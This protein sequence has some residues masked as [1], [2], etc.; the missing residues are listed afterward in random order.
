MDDFRDERAVVVT[1]CTLLC[2][3]RSALQQVVGPIADLRMA[4]R[5]Q[6]LRAVPM[7]A[8]M[9]QGLLQQIAEEL[10]PQTFQPNAVIIRQ[11]EE[12]RKFYIVESGV[13]CITDAHGNKVGQRKQGEFFGEV[14]LIRKEVRQANV[15]ASG[16][17]CRVLAMDRDVRDYSTPPLPGPAVRPRQPALSAPSSRLSDNDNWWQPAFGTACRLDSGGV[18]L[19]TSELLPPPGHLRVCHLQ[20]FE[21]MQS[22]SHR[23]HAQLRN[24]VRGYQPIAFKLAIN[25]LSDVK[26]RGKSWR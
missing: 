8:E 19:L 11:G 12:G 26:A 23:A 15:L 24:V 4:F 18:L 5:V 7:M 21:R 10:E 6:A 13:A 17:G 22:A 20:T 14:A 1:D 16:I 3:T 9:D 25:K 2:L